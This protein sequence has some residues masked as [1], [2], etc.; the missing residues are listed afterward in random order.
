MLGDGR[1]PRATMAHV[2]ISY[3]HTDGDFAV[4]LIRE[5][6][7][8]GFTAWVDRERLRAGEDWRQAID[9]AIRESFA[10]IVI[11]TPEAKASEYVTYEWACG[12]GARVKVIPVLLEATPLHPRLEALQYL[13]FTNPKFRPWDTLKQSLNR[14]RA[15]AAHALGVIGND[16]AVKYL[17]KALRDGAPAVRIAVA[18]ALG[19]IGDESAISELINLM[20][21]DSFEV[22]NVASRSL[23]RIGTLDARAAVEKWRIQLHG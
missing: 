2:F 13:D 17:L 4:A 20:L 14:L 19:A 23:R 11:M 21:S 18:E 12:W 7:K 8:A 22:A 5:I 15:A 16:A 3:A 9:D 1:K 10:L 6:E